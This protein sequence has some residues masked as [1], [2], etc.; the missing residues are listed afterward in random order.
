MTDQRLLK[1]PESRRV[2]VLDGLR[3]V[4]IL[5]VIVYHYVWTGPES[6]VGSVLRVFRNSF[7]MGW[8]GVDLFFVLSGFLIG[9]ILL[10]ARSSPNYY[11][12]FYL[13]RVHRI[14][15]IYYLLVVVYALAAFLAFGH[16]PTPLEMS[17]LKASFL[18][19]HLLFLQNIHMVPGTVFTNQCLSPLWSL[20][21]EEQ[22]YLVAPLLIR[23][24][25][26][27][28]LVVCLLTAILGAPLV[29]AALFY[30]GHPSAA[31]NWM[32]A[33]ADGLAFG[34][35]VAI[36]WRTPS[37]VSW[38]AKNRHAT[39]GSLLMMGGVV[40]GLA[41]LAPS[42]QSALMATV[43]LSVVALFFALVLVA[44]LLP[45]SL[46]AVFMRHRILLEFGTVSY[47]MYLIHDP[48]NPLAHWV[49]RRTWAGFNSLPEIGVT[50]LAF[51]LTWGLARLSWFLLE[52]P[53]MRRGHGYS[54]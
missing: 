3:G 36:L 33:R 10:D 18:P 40:A 51:V 20:A 44:V 19:I 5:F 37:A 53:I 23:Y 54:Y 16:A 47:A 28:R 34:I 17:R 35:L 30:V 24:V 50:L 41:I 22:F 13:R 25:S 11:R 26:R 27:R 38:L 14:L 2:A 8:C 29:R 7:R 49:F 15:P 43:G 42:P 6:P 52:K 32:P 4:A 21:V 46:I 12:T 9:G 39:G 45:G 31:F 1:P 48:L